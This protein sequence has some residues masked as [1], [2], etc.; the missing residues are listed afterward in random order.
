LNGQ[1]D[2][3]AHI[4]EQESVIVDDDGVN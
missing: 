1:A 2:P 4:P 3:L